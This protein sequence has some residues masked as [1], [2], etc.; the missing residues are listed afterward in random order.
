MYIPG[1]HAVQTCFP[2]EVELVNVP[3]GHGRKKD[4]DALAAVFLKPEAKR[5]GTKTLPQIPSSSSTVTA[6]SLEF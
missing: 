2:L 4:I 1:G 3:R 6:S 5:T